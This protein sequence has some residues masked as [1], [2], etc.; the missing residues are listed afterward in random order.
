M[1][2][3]V[4]APVNAPSSSSEGEANRARIF[5][6]NKLSETGGVG[7]S[8]LRK[9]GVNPPDI[10]KFSLGDCMREAEINHT[11]ESLQNNKPIIWYGPEGSGKTTFLTELDTFIQSQN[12]HRAPQDQLTVRRLDFLTLSNLR[13]I[14]HQIENL[15]TDSNTIYLFD[16]ADYLWEKPSTSQGGD[17][18]TQSRI[19]F[20][21]QLLKSKNKLV[22]TAHDQDP[23]G[24]VVDQVAKIKCQALLNIHGVEARALSQEYDQRKIEQVLERLGLPRGLVAEL[25]QSNTSNSFDHATFINTFLGKDEHGSFDLLNW[26]FDM[27]SNRLNPSVI[28]TRLLGILQIRNAHRIQSWA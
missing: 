4:N 5:K 24:V 28:A 21:D 25:M 19:N 11:W 22:M 8:I 2:S 27:I 6:E 16:S 14:S 17:S 7:W 13:N 9:I 1:A 12:S 15:R 23:K 20:L 10:K 26:A 18:L 3:N